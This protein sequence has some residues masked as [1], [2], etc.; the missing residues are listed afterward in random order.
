VSDS[1]EWS[2]KDSITGHYL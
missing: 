1:Q 2:R